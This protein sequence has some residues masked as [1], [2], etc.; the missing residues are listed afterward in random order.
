MD[1][2]SMK[3]IIKICT[4]QWI[5]DS[6]KIVPPQK[7]HE[8]VQAVTTT[9][10]KVLDWTNASWWVRFSVVSAAHNRH[11]HCVGCYLF[12]L[13]MWYKYWSKVLVGLVQIPLSGGGEE[14]LSGALPRRMSKGG[15]TAFHKPIMAVDRC[16]CCMGCARLCASKS[17]TGQSIRESWRPST[18]WW[19]APV[20]G[21][22]EKPKSRFGHL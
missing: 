5:L 13:N 11:R 8:Q 18:S 1:L 20:A 7:Y 19:T 15:Y 12:I 21:V 9:I 22:A 6:Y 4:P 3:F 16:R 14:N 10:R 2:W 17:S